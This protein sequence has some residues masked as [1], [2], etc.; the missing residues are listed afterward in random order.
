[1][2]FIFVNGFVAK[3]SFSKRF[4]FRFSA[5]SFD[6]QGLEVVPLTTFRAG[7]AI[8]WTDVFSRFR[9]FSLDFRFSW[10]LLRDYQ[11]CDLYQLNKIHYH[12]RHLV[13][14]FYRYSADAGFDCRRMRTFYREIVHIL[15]WQRGFFKSSMA[16]S[17]SKSCGSLKL[18]FHSQFFG[19]A[20]QPDLD[21]YFA[22]LIGF[23]SS[24]LS[25][26]NIVL[27]QHFYDNIFT[28]T[29]DRCICLCIINIKEELFRSLPY[30]YSMITFNTQR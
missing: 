21:F 23:F 13:L 15:L 12:D 11:S 26:L 2:L 29:K 27:I 16:F 3:T 5:L 10:L 4:V 9:H 19:T 8:R 25:T 14:N 24:N 1:M 28:T 6:I 7:L 18:G 20:A 22:Y 17:A 30:R